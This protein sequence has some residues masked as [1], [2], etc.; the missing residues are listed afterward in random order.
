MNCVLE[1]F[2]MFQMITITTNI[3]NV[4][5]PETGT[6]DVN[7]NTVQFFKHKIHQYFIIQLN[8]YTFEFHNKYIQDNIFL[9]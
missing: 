5:F 1:G 7:M 4:S 9:V 8:Q 2:Y 6:T 3:H